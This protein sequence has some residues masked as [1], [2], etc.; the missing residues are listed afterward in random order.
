MNRDM[1]LNAQGGHILSLLIAQ[2]AK[3]ARLKA[4]KESDNPCDFTRGMLKGRTYG[5]NQALALVNEH[6]SRT[7]FANPVQAPKVYEEVIAQHEKTIKALTLENMRLKDGGAAEQGAG[8]LEYDVR[9]TI[10]SLLFNNTM[11]SAEKISILQER[12]RSWNSRQG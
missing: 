2:K 5:L 12:C 6:Y 1:P 8:G 9:R 4:I 3:E 7:L 11:S 10:H